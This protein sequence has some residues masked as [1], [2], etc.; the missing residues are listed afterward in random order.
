MDIDLLNPDPTEEKFI[1]S[2][3]AMALGLIGSYWMCGCCTCGPVPISTQ[4]APQAQAH[5]PNSKQFLHGCEVSWLP[6]DY[7]SVQPCTDSGALWKLQSNALPADWRSLD[8]RRLKL[9][10]ISTRD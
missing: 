1:S 6:A 4:A 8:L 3:L 7:Y 5:D 2:A 9:P 10:L